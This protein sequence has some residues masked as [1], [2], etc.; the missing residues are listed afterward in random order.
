MPIPSSLENFTLTGVFVS[1]HLLG[2][3]ADL[4]GTMCSS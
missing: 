3:I 4:P 1:D 2:L